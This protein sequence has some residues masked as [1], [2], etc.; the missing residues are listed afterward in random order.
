MMEQYEAMKE[1]Y[2]DAFLFF[3]LGDFYELFNEDAKKAAQ[4]LEITLTSRN[5]N[6]EDPIPMCGVPHHA[7]DEYV[8]VLIN[9]GYK[10]AIAE[11]MEDPKLTK[12]MVDRQ[13][14]RVITP[15]TYMASGSSDHSNN[16][17]TAL[18]ALGSDRYALGYADISTGELKATELSSFGALES[19]F[20]Q[21]QTKEVVMSEPLSDEQL[22]RLQS[23]QP[24]TLSLYQLANENQEQAQQTETLLSQIEDE[25]ERE[26]LHL[27]LGYIYHTQFQ[28]VGH[29]QQAEHY[30]VDHY[31]HMDYFAKKNL[32]L[33][34]SI[35]TERRTGS[36]LHFIDQ[37]K[38]AM[39]GR[40]LKQ[41]LDR[42]LIIQSDIEKRQDQLASLI[43]HF[44]ERMSIQEQLSG[45]YDLERLVARISMSQVNARELLQLKHSLEQVPAIFSHLETIDQG[46]D[47]Q[48]WQSLLERMETLPEVVDL[49][50]RAINPEAGAVVTEGN[51]INDGFDETLDSY[52]EAM[53]NGHE[54]L[55]NLQTK[56]RE[57][58]GIKSLKI[59][60]NK[61]FGYYI[62]VT[63]ANLSMLPE[64][65]YERKQT[66]ANAE[67]FI[68]PELKEMEQRILEAEEKSTEL[69]YQLFVKVRD[70]IKQYQHPLQMLAQ[71]IASVDVIQALADVS[72]THQFVRPTFA[73]DYQTLQV[74][75]S[76][77]PVVEETIGRD[78]FVPNNIEM[79]NQTHILLITG[80]N[81][82]GK[83]TYM[84]QLGL[85][86][87][88]AQIG[89]FVPA[90]SATLPIF[91]QIFTRIGATD[92]LQAGQSTFMVEMME[93]NQ[94]IQN[95]TDRSLLLFDEIGRGTST[96]DGIAL[97]QAILEYL[98]QHFKAKVLFS[99]HYHE[100]TQL[101]EA[102]P[103]LQNVHV[104]AREE[105]GEVIFLHKVFAGPADK[106]YGIHVAKLAGMPHS[107]LTNATHIL[108]RLE[109]EAV[110]NDP[111]QQMSLFVGEDTSADTLNEKTATETAILDDLIGL[112]VNQLTPYQAFEHIHQWQEQLK[113][114]D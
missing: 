84:R 91:D 18:L 72:E 106:S 93:T 12:G 75:D 74:I 19:E 60:Y 41:W 90:K 30:E 58:T 22:D 107:L 28:T 64:G 112:D 69:E 37:T 42:P 46:S 81:M 104:G 6:S 26:V 8:K 38:T 16:Y 65:R 48:P 24:F 33:T 2:P 11:Q 89:C 54:W 98:D 80:P 111:Y 100:L 103:G 63:R 94:A 53:K 105:N 4:I 92:D 36:L 10:V 20:A 114:D 15:G 34:A 66:L 96:Y 29:W 85:I 77:H 43:D 62:E 109:R 5:K 49:I 71:A 88:L 61:V 47:N 14:I 25:K 35:R 9:Q 13:V 79:D 102:L 68:T 27:L 82:S 55:A 101:E 17:L 97:A 86:V 32:E 56:E 50:K 3:R 110:S 45:V 51:I 23:L 70:T 95:A 31:L 87:I 39:G 67:R 57:V 73:T 78:Q 7:V 52:R 83:S 44:F 59:G 40:L 99:T 21:L 76:R 113:E 1:K 108:E